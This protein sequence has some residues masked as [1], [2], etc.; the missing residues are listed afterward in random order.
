MAMKLDAG[1]VAVVTGGGSGIGRSLVMQLLEAG[2]RVSTCDM[3]PESLEETFALAIETFGKGV[4]DRFSVHVCD[5]TS[6]EA[7]E[8]FRDEVLRDHAGV[9]HVLI[10]NAG[11]STSGSF[12]EMSRERFNR[13]FDVSFKG[14]VECTRAFLPTIVTQSHGAVV[15]LS[16]INAFW[17]TLGTAKWPFASPPHT[18]YSAAKAAVRGF[19]EALL[20][21]AK[22]NFPHVN[23][24]CVHPGHIGT[25]VAANSDVSE[26][27]STAAT[28]GIRGIV[29]FYFGDTAP[30]GSRI[31]DLDAAQ[32]HQKLAEQFKAKAPTTAEQCA[33]QILRAITTGSTR[34]LVGEDAVVFDF[35]ARC[36]PRWIYN[37]R[38]MAFVLLPWTQFAAHNPLGRFGFPVIVPVAVIGLAFGINKLC[39]YF[40]VS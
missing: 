9:V 7:I 14:T 8:L 39:G 2:C 13:T 21:D 19:T 20:C 34:L 1:V 31:D 33:S 3:R 32:L 15:N 10:N 25:N 28:D 26:P 35:C 22:Q 12:L 11:M 23:I 17:C 5:V 36:F 16:S 6:I 24:C 18:P 27:P 4:K 37:D 38:F 29:K 40:T 30:D